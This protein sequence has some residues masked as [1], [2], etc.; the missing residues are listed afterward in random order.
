[1]RHARLGLIAL[2]VLLI[3]A[4]LLPAAVPAVLAAV[5]NTPS[6]TPITST[7]GPTETPGTPGPTETPGPPSSGIDLDFSKTASSNVANV[8]ALIEF[9]LTV[10]NLGSEDAPNVVMS[11]GLDLALGYVG[12]NCS[13]G[14]VAYDGVNRVVNFNLGTINA[15][16]TVTCTLQTRVNDNVQPPNPILNTAS[17]IVNNTLRRTSNQITLQTVPDLLPQTGF[18]PGPWPTIGL[19]LLAAALPLGVWWLLRRRLLSK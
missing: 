1:M 6:P 16:Q 18:A 9:T 14:E 19:A 13:Q 2:A 7:P 17:L 8:G 5:T 15:G 11:D 12:A 3:G 10:R 4:V